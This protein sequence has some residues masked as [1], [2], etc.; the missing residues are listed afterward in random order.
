[1]N[2]FATEEKIK[3]EIKP[4]LNTLVIS[5]PNSI[6]KLKGYLKEE[7]GELYWEFQKR[8]DKSYQTVL[9]NWIPLKGNIND[10]DYKEI[11]RIW[12]LNYEK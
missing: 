4:Y 6:V 5:P 2:N 7:D 12:N 9:M 1:M 3:E 11:E 10:K 8:Y